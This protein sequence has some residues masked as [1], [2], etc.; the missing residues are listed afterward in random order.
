[1]TKEQMEIIIQ[2]NMQKIYLYCIKKL[3]NTAVAEDV[4]SDIILSCFVLIPESKMM[5]QYMG[6]CGVLQI[7][8]AGITG[9]GARKKLAIKLRIILQVLGF[10]LQKKAISEKKKSCCCEES[11]PCLGKSIA[12]L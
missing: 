5:M 7:I 12:G 10:F 11:Y 6:I 1:M 8:Y 4:A 2:E 3:G 9:E